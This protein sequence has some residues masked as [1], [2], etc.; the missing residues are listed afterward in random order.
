MKRRHRKKGVNPKALAWLAAKQMPLLA[1]AGRATPCWVRV[2]DPD[3]N[4]DSLPEA[5]TPH[6]GCPSCGSVWVEVNAVGFKMPQDCRGHFEAAVYIVRVQQVVSV[7]AVMLTCAAG[8][9]LEYDGAEFCAAPPVL[10]VSS[11]TW[12]AAI[13]APVALMMMGM[14]KAKRS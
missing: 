3:R 4:P 7:S 9:R 13:A 6:T 8:H 11:A 10:G 5:F 14:G 12:L 1:S 2:C